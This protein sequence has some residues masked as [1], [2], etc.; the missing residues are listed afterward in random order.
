[1]GRYG[2][3]RSRPYPVLRSQTVKGR[4][5]MVVAAND[6]VVGKV[7]MFEGADR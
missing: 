1:M 3:K 2:A 6:D 4:D 5:P 7:G